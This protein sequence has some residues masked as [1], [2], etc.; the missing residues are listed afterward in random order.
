MIFCYQS[1]ERLWRDKN[2]TAALRGEAAEVVPLTVMDGAESCYF[3]EDAPARG[4]S[5]KRFFNSSKR[6]VVDSLT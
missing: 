1:R 4:R 3:S 5:L 2:E 6:S